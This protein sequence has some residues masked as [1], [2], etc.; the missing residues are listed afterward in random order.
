MGIPW[1]VSWTQP[2]DL[3]VCSIPH[4]PHQPAGKEKTSGKSRRSAESYRPSPAALSRRELHASLSWAFALTRSI[5]VCR[6]SRAGSLTSSPL[7][8]ATFPSLGHVNVLG[9]TALGADLL[10]WVQRRYGCTKV[11]T[12]GGR[13]WLPRRGSPDPS[14]ALRGQR[15]AERGCQTPRGECRVVKARTASRLVTWKPR[16]GPKVRRSPE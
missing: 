10:S 3:R 12:G 2:G 16:R 9:I 4:L 8:Y 1:P 11:C 6:R 13:G 7:R 14:P 5:R 15:G